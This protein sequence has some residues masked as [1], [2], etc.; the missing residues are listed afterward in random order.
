MTNRIG[1]KLHVQL[2]LSCFKDDRSFKKRLPFAEAASVLTPRGY[3]IIFIALQLS[4]GVQVLENTVL[5]K[6]EQNERG[7]SAIE[8]LI[9]PL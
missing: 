8:S 3:P 9:S 1:S 2:L 7:K 6:K 5:K 4:F